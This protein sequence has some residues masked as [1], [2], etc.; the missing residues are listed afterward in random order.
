MINRPSLRRHLIATKDTSFSLDEMLIE[1]LRFT[2]SHDS[3]ISHNPLVSLVHERQRMPSHHATE[4]TEDE[5]ESESRPSIENNSDE[6]TS[7]PP[8]YYSI[9]HFSSR[10]QLSFQ[11]LAKKPMNKT[12]TNIQTTKALRPMAISSHASRPKP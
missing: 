1:C 5:T 8:R 2:R 9:P 4:E 10:H 7:D 6:H 3:S 12:N 11:V